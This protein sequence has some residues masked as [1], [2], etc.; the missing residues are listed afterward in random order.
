MLENKICKYKSMKVIF[1]RLDKMEQD[2]KD[3]D[4]KASMG[5][6]PL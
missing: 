1:K 2:G 3:A 5:I 4:L 6:L